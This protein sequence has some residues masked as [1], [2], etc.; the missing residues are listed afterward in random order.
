MDDQGVMNMKCSRGANLTMNCM[1]IKRALV[2][3][4]DLEIRM[5]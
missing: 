4:E 3:W 2:G 5:E 1:F